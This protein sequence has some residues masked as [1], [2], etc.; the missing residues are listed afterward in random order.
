M[1]SNCLNTK[2][3]N[4][5]TSIYEVMEIALI[6]QK[7]NKVTLFLSNNFFFKTINKKY[8][9]KNLNFV[10]L[11]IFKTLNIIFSIFLN[12]SHNVIKKLIS[13]FLLNKIKRKKNKVKFRENIYKVAFFPHKG[14]F[15]RE[16]L[17][18]YFYLNKIKSNFNKKNIAHIEWDFSDLNKKD[19]NYYSKNN[20]PLFFWN[21]YSYKKLSSI[22]VGKFLISNLGLIYKISKF[23]VFIELLKSIYQINNALEKIKINFTQLEYILI[24]Y[25]ILF[26]NE[27]SIAC[28]HLN[29][30]TVSV[31]TRILI[32]S[33]ATKMS[34]DYYFIL[35]PSSKKILKKRMGRTIKFFYPTKITNKISTNLKK[36]KN[37]KKLKCLVIDYH[38]L[39]EKK[40]YENGTS[41]NSWKINLD[42]YSNILILSKKY[43]NILFLIKSKNYVWLKHEYFKDFVKILAKQKNVK[44][45]K[46]QKK[47]TPKYS[48]KITDFAIAKYSSLSDQMLYQNKPVI[49][50][51]YDGFPGLLYDFGEKIL[52]NNF[53]D[54]KYK[55]DCIQKNYHNYNKS[56][57]QI[58]KSLFFSNIKGDTIKNL[59]TNF[60]QKLIN[61]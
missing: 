44:I 34:F 40:W 25:D 6:L 4:D 21:S 5:V 22:Y 11:D 30:K 55:T 57:N 1:L 59:L 39:E 19:I 24:G 31:Q 13:I 16:G 48:V 28:K 23:S 8:L 49:I 61:N 20:I 18:D 32:P 51:N 33:W 52:T 58:R 12:I 10:N 35:G 29:I 26:A 2:I 41:I 37:T 50:F 7:R 45:L 15:D 43:P 54:L 46:D 3:Y 56:L 60:D 27:I 38:S 42:F 53:N 17:K 14:I 36:L 47:W 9:L